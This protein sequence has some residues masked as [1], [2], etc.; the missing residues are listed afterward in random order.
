MFLLLF[1]LFCFPPRSVLTAAPF[2]SQISF[3]SSS[4][5]SSFSACVCVLRAPVRAQ[6]R[7]VAWRRGPCAAR[8]SL[9]ARL[10]TQ[11]ALLR[12][13]P[14]N[15]PPADSEEVHRRR[16]RCRRPFRLFP[17]SYCTARLGF[18][19]GSVSVSKFFLGKTVH[20]TSRVF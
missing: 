1:W 8:V 3:S 18:Q 4:S 16:R 6:V 20:S 7:W 12:R 2:K 17:S 9:R 10:V 5:Y 14:A 13:R 15:A 19:T 11:V